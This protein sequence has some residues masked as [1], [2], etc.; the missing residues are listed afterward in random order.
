M[1]LFQHHGIVCLIC[2][3]I[4]PRL[5]LLLGSFVTGG[6]L[7]WLGWIFTPHLLVALLSLQYW[8]TNPLLAVIAWIVAL[9]GTSAETKTVTHKRRHDA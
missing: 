9:G 2:L 5:T 3:A 8:N 7:W 1:N 4:F 6:V